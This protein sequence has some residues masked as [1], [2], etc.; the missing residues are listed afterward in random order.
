MADLHHR[1]RRAGRLRVDEL[2]VRF[3]L[4][5]AAGQMVMKYSGG[6]RRASTWR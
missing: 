1:G 6:M 2:L 5:D 3:D 4:V